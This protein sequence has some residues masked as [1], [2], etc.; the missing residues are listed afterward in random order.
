V[1]KCTQTHQVD[2]KKS[3][4]LWEEVY[5][6]SASLLPVDTLLALLLRA[7]ALWAL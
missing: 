2:A 1:S 4:I 6:L 3:Q 7:T 5:A